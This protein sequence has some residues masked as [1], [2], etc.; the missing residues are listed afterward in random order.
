MKLQITPHRGH[1][2]STALKAVALVALV[3]GV[4]YPALLWG[5]QR[6]LPVA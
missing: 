1:R 5:L 3:W 6:A 4:A 2:L